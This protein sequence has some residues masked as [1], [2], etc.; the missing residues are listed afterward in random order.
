MTNA[1]EWRVMVET[2]NGAT[3]LQM[4]ALQS[5]SDKI[6]WAST[7]YPHNWRPEWVLFHDGSYAHLIRNGK[8]RIVTYAPLREDTSS[9]LPGGL[10]AL[11][12]QKLP[13]LVLEV[14]LVLD[15]TGEKVMRT[16]LE[17]PQ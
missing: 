17:A 2:Y 11:L 15:P 14:R 12:G 13:N 6:I 5:H 1:I 16:Q 4:E 9:L 3:E 10:V 8:P 7:N